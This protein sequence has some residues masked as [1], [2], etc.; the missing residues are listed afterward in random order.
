[1]CPILLESGT[2]CTSK[3]K[4]IKSYDVITYLVFE[5]LVSKLVLL[6]YSEDLDKAEYQCWI[7]NVKNSGSKDVITF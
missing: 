6:N 4:K 1:M 7:K 2:C 5:M 3:F